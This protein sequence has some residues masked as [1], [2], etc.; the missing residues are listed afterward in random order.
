[1][2]KRPFC[3]QPLFDADVKYILWF[4][5]Q[6]QIGMNALSFILINVL[7]FHDFESNQTLEELGLIPKEILFVQQK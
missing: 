6:N 4:S 2:E 3:S 5:L 1:M 7:N